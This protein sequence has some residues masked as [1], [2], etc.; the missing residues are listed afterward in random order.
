MF[1]N[2]KKE[3]VDSLPLS[4]DLQVEIGDPSMIKVDND[5]LIKANNPIDIINY[6]NPDT[7]DLEKLIHKLQ[8]E[9]LDLQNEVGYYERY[10]KFLKDNYIF[11]LKSLDCVKDLYNKI[12]EQNEKLD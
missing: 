5:K 1:F 12:G 7:K 10:I 6:S 2:R 11:I 8:V 9:N 4:M 3:K